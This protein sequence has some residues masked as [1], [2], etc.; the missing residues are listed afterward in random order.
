M[1]TP[2]GPGSA[3]PPPPHAPRCIT[4]ALGCCLVAS[5]SVRLARRLL[6]SC[7]FLLVRSQSPTQ[8]RLHGAITMDQ[9]GACRLQRPSGTQ[10]TQHSALE[11]AGVDTGTSRRRGANGGPTTTTSTSVGIAKH[12]TERDGRP[13]HGRQARSRRRPT[14]LGSTELET[15]PR[16]WRGPA[17]AVAG[18]PVPSGLFRA[19]SQREWHAQRHARSPP[20]CR[21]AQARHRPRGATPRRRAVGRRPGHL[22]CPSTPP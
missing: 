8:L 18:L 13:P 17:L 5:A 16:Q 20:A 6:L 19:P 14:Y 12:G 9:N 7:N 10:G 21:A 1:H 22:P 2:H 15:A 11:A 4:A 3:V